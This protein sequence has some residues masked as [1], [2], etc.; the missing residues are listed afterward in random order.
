MKKFTGIYFLTAALFIAQSAVAQ[1][2]S[3][4]DEK[5]LNN[6]KA[7]IGFLADDKLEGRRTGSAGEK[8]AYEYIENG[9]KKAGLLAGSTNNSFIQEFDVNDGLAVSKPTSLTIAGKELELNKNFFPYP[10]SADVTGLEFDPAS[11]DIVRFDLAD[12]IAKN[13]NNPHFDLTEEIINTAKKA[14]SE[15]KML[16]IVQA[17]ADLKEM[18]VFDAKDKHEKL[19][20]PVIFLVN[21]GEQTA[22]AAAVA[23][24]TAAK[25][26]LS[27][28]IIQK[29]RTG[30]NVIGFTNNN[31]K[32]TVI[33]GAH[34]DHLGYGEDHNSLYAGSEK[35]IHNGADDNASGTAA[36]IELARKTQ[37]LF[38]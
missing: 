8:L 31:A 33:L 16:M 7:S 22:S 26:K 20:I 34:Y 4:E 38:Q 35:M 14:S 37:R 1:Q 2:N 18:P 21:A 32:N 23:S 5:T 29:H 13:S 30:H 12:V 24:I 17:S 11:P 36:L 3:K 27:I 10:F 9:F 19:G 6:I 28:H 25:A 15:K